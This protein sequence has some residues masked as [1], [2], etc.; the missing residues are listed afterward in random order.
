MYCT[1]CRNLYIYMYTSAMW[2]GISEVH[3][4]VVQERIPSFPVY[5]I[6][7]ISHW[8]LC[9]ATSSCHCLLLESLVAMLKFRVHSTLIK[10]TEV[11][12]F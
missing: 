1:W 3:T 9:C 5:G 10:L 8:C 7:S 6:T 2:H 12:V 4:F 11:V